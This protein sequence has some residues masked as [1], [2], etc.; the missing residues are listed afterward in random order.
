[1]DMNIRAEYFFTKPDHAAMS[2]VRHASTRPES[3]LIYLF[4]I[5]AEYQI[6]AE[7]SNIFLLLM[8]YLENAVTIINLTYPKKGSILIT[9]L[10]NEIWS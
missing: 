6:Y 10:K 8:K 7:K 9:A 1:M 5:A 3:S 4:C 2:L